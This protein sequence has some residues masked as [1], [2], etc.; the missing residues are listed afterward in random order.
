MHNTVERNIR[1]LRKAGLSEE[2]LEAEKQAAREAL[3]NV[4]IGHFTPEEYE[5]AG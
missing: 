4:S 3:D 1:E 2:L 5:V